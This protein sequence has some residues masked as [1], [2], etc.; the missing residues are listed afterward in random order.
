MCA[1]MK[2]LSFNMEFPL[3]YFLRKEKLKLQRIFFDSFHC[4]WIDRGSRSVSLSMS[5]WPLFRLNQR[6]KWKTHRP[7]HT[8]NH[9]WIMCLVIL[10]SCMCFLLFFFIESS[11]DSYKKRIYIRQSSW[12]SVS[13]ERSFLLY[14]LFFD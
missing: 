9:I 13:L 3:A 8:N 14:V 2:L 10:F 12:K 7:Y 1:R 6:I 5:V 11:T 4:P